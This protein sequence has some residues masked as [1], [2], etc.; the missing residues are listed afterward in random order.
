M[1]RL[2]T[3]EMY[4]NARDTR[5]ARLTALSGVAG[6]LAGLLLGVLVYR[7]Y[8]YRAATDAGSPS[9]SAPPAAV[10]DVSPPLITAPTA[11]LTEERLTSQNVRVRLEWASSDRDGAVIRVDLQQSVNFADWKDV[12]LDDPAAS[13]V[14]QSLKPGNLYQF[15]AR[16]RDGAANYSAWQT[17]PTF[18]LS[19]L[20]ES[21]SEIVYT[22]AW[23]PG[24]VTDAY[25][26]LVNYASDAGAAAS[27]TF[28][29]QGI[30][31]VSTKGPDRGR[32]DVWLDGVRVATVDLFWSS[33]IGSRKTVFAANGL[34]AGAHTLDIRVVG[35][36][37]D[38]SAGARVDIDAFVILR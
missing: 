19:A 16:A 21:A 14:I 26:E 1:R 6:L 17:G 34:G 7:S 8:A 31:W 36:G 38:A 13:A 18:T 20:Q 10:L 2:Q 33:D 24:A 29:G 15:R 30:S 23:S 9:S 12:S 35:A 32:A 5:V 4:D 37:R 25:G 3:I 22:G 11:R 28:E 27:L